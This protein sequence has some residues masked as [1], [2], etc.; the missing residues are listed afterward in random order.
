MGEKH[1][2]FLP[3]LEFLIDLEGL[4]KYLG[5]KIGQG[6]LC[7][8]CNEKKNAF[9]SLDAVRKHMKVSSAVDLKITFAMNSFCLEARLVVICLAHE[10]NN[11]DFIFRN[12]VLVKLI[13]KVLFDN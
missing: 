11:F 12:R 6:H 2:F 9:Q 8:W 5:A 13:L 3:D 1:S 10:D 4:L 7:I